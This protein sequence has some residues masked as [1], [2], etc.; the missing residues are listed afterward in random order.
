MWSAIGVFGFV[1][2]AEGGGCVSEVSGG[3][4]GEIGSSEGV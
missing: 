2:V 4:W 1:G 3:G